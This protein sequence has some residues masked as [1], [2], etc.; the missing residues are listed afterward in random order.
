MRRSRVPIHSPPEDPFFSSF[1]GVKS[2]SIH[3]LPPSPPAAAH[4]G[5]GI[6]ILLLSLSLFTTLSINSTTTT[7]IY[8]LST[9]K[10]ALAETSE[11]SSSTI[12]NNHSSP[13]N[14]CRYLQ[15]TIA[16]TTPTPVYL[17]IRGEGDE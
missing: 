16:N 4:L 8:V 17:K 12:V 3:P 1:L 6:G 5:I 10:R 13:P 15:A 14:I 7:L 11:F 2:T 9:P